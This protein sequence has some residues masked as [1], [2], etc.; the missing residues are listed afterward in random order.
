MTKSIVS[1][2]KPWNKM[3]RMHW[4]K[5]IYSLVGA[6]ISTVT[7][8]CD[9]CIQLAPQQHDTGLLLESIE[10][11]EKY[12]EK[13]IKNVEDHHLNRKKRYA[14]LFNGN[15]NYLMDIQQQ[16]EELY[17]KLSR[18]SR[19]FV[20]VYNPF[21]GFLYNLASKL[22]FRSA[23]KPDV[24]ITEKNL[25]TFAR[26][27]GYE[28]VRTRA[29]VFI[30]FYIPLLSNLVN[31]VLPVLPFVKRFA[32]L[33]VVVLRPIIPEKNK[34]SL[35]IIIPA[36]NEAGNIQ[37]AIQRIPIIPG[38]D[39]E[40]I[41]VE[42][43]STDDTWQ[44]IQKILEDP[45]K[46]FK[47]KAHKQPGKG[48]NDAVR[49]GFDN[50]AADL[51]TILDAD[52]TMPPEMLPRFYEAYCQGLGDF[53]N[54]SRLVYPMENEAMRPLNRMGN[55]FFCKILSFVL[56]ISVSDSLCGTK[57]YALDDYKRF[58]SWRDRFG[59]FDPFGDFEMLFAS[60]ELA[61]GVIDLPVRYRARTYGE[62]N[63]SRFRNGFE[64]IRMTL[65]GFFR[66]LLGKVK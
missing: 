9:E 58:V 42:G 36:R 1:E 8:F 5:Y 7:R 38:A 48:K 40:I 37:D 65:I 24:Y 60:S 11:P 41:F 64:L 39:V 17:I 29:S 55:L 44:R 62:T 47:I 30:P 28:I 12:Q 35:S 31:R 59:D 23:P 13:D 63:I 20:I 2:R 3:S 6:E 15:F 49:V 57:F 16:L 32:L 25:K 21:L 54:G 46:S 43:N 45:P 10:C 50:A 18:H 14:F 53:V 56:G 19:L 51:V 27:A 52:L 34:P 33:W 66:I 4:K 61:L 22:R 26:L